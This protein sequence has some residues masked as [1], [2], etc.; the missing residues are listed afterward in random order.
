MQN[1]GAD[2]FEK[3]FCANLCPSCGNTEKELPKDNSI[4]RALEYCLLP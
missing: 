2:S 4:L 1:E 3:E